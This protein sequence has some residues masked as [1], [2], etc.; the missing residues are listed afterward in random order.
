MKATFGGGCFWCTEVIFQNTKG[1]NT[2]L[3]GYMGGKTDNPTYKEVCNGDTDHV[4]V[5]QLDF[6]EHEVS[7]EELLK[8]FFKTHDPTTLNRQGNDIGTQYRSVVFYH[9]EAQREAT[10]KFIQHLEDEQVFADPIVTTVEPAVTFWEA[11]DY[12]HDY[13]NQNPGNPFCAAVIAPKL[14]KFLKEYQG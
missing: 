14:Q 2:V 4:E 6:D 3:P 1:V 12:H 5:V 7:F 10:E 13:F 8:V 9:N 11:E